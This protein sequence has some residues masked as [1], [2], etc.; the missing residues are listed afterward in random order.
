[1]VTV[2]GTATLS[3]N[4]GVGLGAG[5]RLYLPYV[6]QF[7]FSLRFGEV[8]W[9]IFLR[10]K[11]LS[12]ASIGL[13]ETVF[14]IASILGEV[15]TGVMADRFGRKWSLA[16]GRL[17]AALSAGIMLLSNDPLVL[18]V[19]FALNAL[20]YTCHSGAYEALLYDS[21]ASGMNGEFTRVLGTANSIYLL[22]TFL[23]AVA[24]GVVGERSLK[25]LYALSIA[26]DLCCFG[27]A[28]CLKEP[29][30]IRRLAAPGSPLERV[31]KNEQLAGL[32]Q[33]MKNPFLRSLLFVWA[34]TGALTASVKFYGQALLKDMAVPL[35]GI[36]AAS[37]GANLI[38]MAAAR[39][40]HRW[41]KRLGRERALG[42]GSALLPASVMLALAGA[43][44][45]KGSFAR[46]MVTACYIGPAVM[47]EAL[48]PI[49]SNAVN[50]IV[51]APHRATVLSTAGMLFSILMTV[52]FPAIGALGDRTGLHFGLAVAALAVE[53]AILVSLFRSH[54]ERNTG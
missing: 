26:V 8:F 7:L 35:S 36:A 39:S 2:V 47:N 37:A 41:E 6:Y 14:H 21:L 23:T 27:A 54:P 24:A 10:S 44:L 1:M 52:L 40:A 43:S 18:A 33:A 38:G 3:Y 32:V 4:E 16:V 22:G 12:L 48:Y 19:A 17:L 13:V 30:K 11:G 9:V 42:G 34:A 50:S 51:R 45:S 15:P 53:I 49:F 31:G 20:S 5:R 29:L 46:A 25:A 28:A